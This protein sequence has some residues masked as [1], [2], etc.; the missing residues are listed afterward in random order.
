MA[1]KSYFQ[2]LLKSGQIYPKLYKNVKQGM[3]VIGI[4]NVAK[5]VEVRAELVDTF[6]DVDDVDEIPV[7]KSPIKLDTDLL[8]E[9]APIEA[10]K[11][12]LEEEFT[13][14]D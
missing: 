8:L 9:E 11:A 1:D 4:R 6:Y 12:D 2:F 3:G 7:I 5:V 13:S 10:V 14:E